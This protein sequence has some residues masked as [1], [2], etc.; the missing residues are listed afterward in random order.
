MLTPPPRSDNP[1][2]DT[3]RNDTPH[4]NTLHINTPHI[5]TPTW[6][7]VGQTYVLAA[8]IP[9]L[10]WT[11][12]NPIAGTVTLA[13]IAVTAIGVKRLDVLAACLRDCGEFAFE[14]GD[15]ARVT[16]SHPARDDICC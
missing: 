4:I 12:A 14:L 5:D 7:Q 15:T 9:V 10:F 3:S 13:G 16:V 2:I 1:R 6:S 11:F 8:L